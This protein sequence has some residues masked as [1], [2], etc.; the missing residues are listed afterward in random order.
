MLIWNMIQT[1]FKIYLEYHWALINVFLSHAQQTQ[2]ICIKFLQRLPNVFD[3]DPTL[4]K[5]STHILCLL[6]GYGP[7]F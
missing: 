6:G 4:Y 2:N 1:I 5:S 3:V 7:V